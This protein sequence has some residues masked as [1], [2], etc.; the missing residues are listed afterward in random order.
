MFNIVL[1]DHTRI[2]LKNSRGPSNNYMAI[3]M[4]YMEKII[5]LEIQ[6]LL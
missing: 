3:S 1:D 4:R 5:Q 2:R 6:K